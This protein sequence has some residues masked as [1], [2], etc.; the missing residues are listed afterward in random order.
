M[1]LSRNGIIILLLVS[2]LLGTTG[3]S[4]APKSVATRSENVA[5]ANSATEKFL[6]SYNLKT[7]GSPTKFSM[8]IPKNWDVNLGDFPIG[9]YWRLANEF[10]KDSGLDLT[11]LKGTTVEVWRYSLADGLPGQKEQS[12][13]NYPSNV[14]LLVK[15]KKVVGD[16]LTFNVCE[17]GPSVKKRYINDITGITF[18]QWVQKEGVFQNNGKNK[19]IDFLQPVEVLKAFFKAIDDGDK[20]RAYAC[21]SPNEMLDSLTM[22]LRGNYLYNSG[23][24]KDDSLV[25]SIVSVI[26][27]SFKMM[28]S[29]NFTQITKIENR[30]EIEIAVEGEMKWADSRFNSVNGKDERFAGMKKYESG[31]KILGLGTGP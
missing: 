8:E 1:R 26:P 12:I 3:C 10:S 4:T 2:M 18:E 11:P 14:I 22:N 24:T 23:F 7:K 25:E 6:K 17:I 15:G 13:Y 27:T 30:T 21:L 28:D 9:L 20:T 16:W 19:D 31:W 29:T 5:E